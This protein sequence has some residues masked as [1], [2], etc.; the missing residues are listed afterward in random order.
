MRP[1]PEIEMSHL[2][3][4]PIVVP[5]YF[6]YERV[7]LDQL[8]AFW[9]RPPFK[10]ALE[11][12]ERFVAEQRT[13]LLLVPSSIFGEFDA[14]LNP[15]H[16]D[17]PQISVGKYEPVLSSD[18]SLL[19]TRHMKSDD[20]REVFLCHASKDK[21]AIV[22]PLYTSLFG[23]GVSAWYDNADIQWGDR[24]TKKISEGLSKS[25]FV[26]VIITENF[27][28]SKFA[29]GEFESVLNS[30]LTHGERRLLPLL[31]GTPDFRQRVMTE[32]PLI[33]DR[34]Y[35]VWENNPD[36]IAEAFYDLITR[37]NGLA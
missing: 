37:S 36:E 2:R 30:D 13:A 25:K 10:E 7:E 22:K 12:G 5:P 4:L 21:E 23:M 34:L 17:F 24:I 15:A 8:S 1:G 27:F 11:I 29:Q 35:K 26:M 33:R 32:N 18:D 19:A 31:A 16:P 14:V 6:E 28:D 3:G 9:Y 20:R